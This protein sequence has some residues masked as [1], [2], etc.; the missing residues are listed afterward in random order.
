MRRS[1]VCCW[2]RERWRRRAESWCISSRSYQVYSANILHDRHE[3]G[4]KASLGLKDLR[5]AHAAAEQLGRKLPMLEAVRLR[6]GEA[7]DAG[8]SERDW[9]V[10]ADYTIRSA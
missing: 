9:S 1:A 5:L 7:V 2:R 3:P 10:M 8:G 4:S 6:I